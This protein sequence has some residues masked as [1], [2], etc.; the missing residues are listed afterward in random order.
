MHRNMVRWVGLSFG[1]LIVCVLAIGAHAASAQTP[2]KSQAK[3]AKQ[4]KQDK[5]QKAPE[6]VITATGKLVITTIDDEKEYTLQDSAGK[7]LYYLEAG[8]KWF[9]TST[10]YPLDKYA[11]Q[12]V[13]VVGVVEGPKPAKTPNPN[14]NPNATKEKDD[15]AKRTDAPT[16]DVRSVN[17]VAIRAAGKP[18]W[19]GG[20]KNVPNH[21]GSKGK[22]HDKSN[23]GKSENGKKAP[24]ANP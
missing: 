8:P 20:P 3:Q 12:N 13:T 6:T 22:G 17:G 5:A 19:A 14:A 24:P 18:P 15:A 16:L 9:Y 2:A 23:N 7:K 11:N 21:P 4:A 10:A 1:L